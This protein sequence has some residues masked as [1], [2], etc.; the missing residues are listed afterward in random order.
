MIPTDPLL[1][2]IKLNC[3]QCS[4]LPIS[5]IGAL[6]TNEPLAITKTSV[7]GKAPIS[8]Y[9]NPYERLKLH[10]TATVNQHHMLRA[11]LA[12]MVKDPPE[13]ELVIT[14][15]KSVKI[16]PTVSIHTLQIL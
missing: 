10:D 16:E 6:R 2:Q 8:Q 1:K 13:E 3:R 15:P 11:K 12:P 9:S 5:S 7:N 4:M 14:F